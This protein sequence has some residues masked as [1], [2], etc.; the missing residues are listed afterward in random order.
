MRL[1]LKANAIRFISKSKT[2]RVSLRLWFAVLEGQCDVDLI[3]RYIMG[4]QK[5]PKSHVCQLN[6]F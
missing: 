2:G 1:T 4:W 3:Y 6:I 5:L